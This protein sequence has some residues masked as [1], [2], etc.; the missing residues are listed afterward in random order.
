M[1]KIRVGLGVLLIVLAL[2]LS[3]L[4]LV[5]NNAQPEVVEASS[6]SLVPTS[7]ITATPEPTEIEEVATA[8]S[9]P[10][11]INPVVGYVINDRVDLS[12]GNPTSLS[13][14]LPDDSLLSSNWAGAVPYSGEDDP[15]TVFLPSKGVIYSYLG[16]VMT[17]WAHSGINISGQ[18]YFATNLDLFIRKSSVN[19]TV[20][21]IPEAQVKAESLKGLTAYLCQTETGEVTPLS[22]YDATKGCPGRVVEMEV[23][24]VAVIP[25]E[26]LT[27]YNG[28][29]LDINS[30]LV[31]NY[32]GAGF[33]KLDAGN[34]WLIRFCIGKLSDQVSD[35][36]HGYTYN[37]GIIGFRIVE[38]GEQ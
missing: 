20:V 34:G 13:I 10:V 24:A 25:H 18:R 36:S 9:T 32:P 7:Y 22:N 29:I 33:E 23:V 27:E 31:E 3:G 21:S 35:G 11:V 28:A 12:S 15:D 38:D 17:T 19:G 37:R 8:T 16:D 5:G 1:S 26:K 4:K 14:R 6:V 30:W 2:G